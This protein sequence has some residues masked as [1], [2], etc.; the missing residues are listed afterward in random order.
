MT[1]T[2]ASNIRLIVVLLMAVGAFA[3]GYV[4]TTSARLRLVAHPTTRGLYRDGVFTG[5]GD[6]IH[7]RVQ[8]TVTIRRGRIVS[9]QI[10]KCRMR[11]PCSMIAALPAQV[12]ERQSSAVDLVTGATQ[13]AEAFSQAVDAALGQALR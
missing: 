12:E 1:H 9:A 6:S 4:R 3:L 8:A 10:A 7:G 5:W 13:S 11:Y 2:R